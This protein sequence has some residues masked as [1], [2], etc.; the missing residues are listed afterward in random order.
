MGEN[1]LLPYLLDKRINFLDYVFISH[2]DTDH[3]GGLLA[4]MQ[5]I[6]VKNVIIGKQFEICENYQ[7]FIKIVREKKIKVGVV[8]AGQRINIEKDLY[9]DVLWPD[10]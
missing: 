6:K 7:E 4:V 8:E 9:F 5:E 10:S 3:V 2:F 1:I